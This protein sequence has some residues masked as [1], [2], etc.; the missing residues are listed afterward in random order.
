MPFQTLKVL[1]KMA[2]LSYI[3]IGYKTTE[4]TNSYIKCLKTL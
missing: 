1:L 4:I 2:L 3:S